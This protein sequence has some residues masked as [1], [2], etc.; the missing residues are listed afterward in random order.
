MF[1]DVTSAENQFVPTGFVPYRSY[2]VSE[3]HDLLVYGVDDA[4]W[5]EVA[6]KG[7]DGLRTVYMWR[8]RS[9]VQGKGLAGLI[10]R[11]FASPDYRRLIPDELQWLAVTGEAVPEAICLFDS[12]FV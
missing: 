11:V 7:P 10:A 3:A 8:V 9:E 4:W 12:H 5:V 2:L 6:R 1:L